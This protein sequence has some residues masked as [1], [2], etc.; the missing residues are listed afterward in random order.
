MLTD[1]ARAGPR[2]SRPR[3][4]ADKVAVGLA[5]H[6]RRA[7][8]GPRGLGAE[9]RARRPGR[10]ELGPRRATGASPTA[11]GSGT[12]C[13]RRLMQGYLAIGETV[14]GL[15]DDA[16]LDWRAERRRGFAAGNMRRRARADELP[17]VEPDGDQGDDRHAAASNLVRGARTARA[18]RRQGRGCPRSSTRASSTSART[19]R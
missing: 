12:G 7:A 3:A 16:D 5:R 18:R 8:A 4:P 15:I 2:A 19:W 14:D 6:P 9:L 10:S 13:F 11:R 17:V 1:A